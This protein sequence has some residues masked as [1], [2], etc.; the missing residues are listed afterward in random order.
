MKRNVFRIIMI[1]ICLL[2]AISSLGLV[3]SAIGWG[4]F[5]HLAVSTQNNLVIILPL[6]GILYCVL[7]LM[8]LAIPSKK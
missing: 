6:M 5:D 2:G 3:I 8:F 4:T 7:G 1:I